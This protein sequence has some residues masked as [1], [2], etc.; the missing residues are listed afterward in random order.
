M[1]SPPKR[2]ALGARLH[3]SREMPVTEST[4]ALAPFQNFRVLEQ[5]QDTGHPSSDQASFRAGR[6]GEFWNTARR[7]AAR[8][9]IS[10]F[11]EISEIHSA[12]NIF[13]M[14]LPDYQRSNVSALGPQL[15]LA[16]LGG[17]AIASDGLV[18]FILPAEV[19]QEGHV[20]LRLPGFG[21]VD[22][23]KRNDATYFDA[24]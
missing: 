1:R 3:Y 4:P 17:D 15:C 5:R 12:R 18:G 6:G 13:G 19:Q 2:L 8:S 14:F 11:L 10:P 22:R 24:R 20:I 21:I 7:W 16:E 23:Q 9:P